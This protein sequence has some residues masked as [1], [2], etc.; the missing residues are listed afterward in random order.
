MRILRVAQ[1]V[2]PAVKGGGPYHVHAMSRDQATMGHDVTV[3]TI[4]TNPELPSIEERDGYTVIRYDPTCTVLGNDVSLDLAQYLADPP[5][6]DVIHAHSHLYFCSNLAAVRRKLTGDVPLVLTNHGLHSQNVS[7]N[8]FKMYLRTVG[9]WTFNQ[10]DLVFCYTSE[11]KERA[12]KLGITSE[13]EI[14]SNGIDPGR[15]TPSGSKHDAISESAFSVVSPIRLVP[16]KRPFD[17]V[18]AIERVSKQYPGVELYLCG[19]GPLREELESYIAKRNLTDVVHL[20]GMVPYDE[21][22]NV[23]RSADLVVLP[24]EA[25]GGSPRALLEGMATETPFISPNLPQIATQL[26]ELGGTTDVGDV[27]GLAAE[28]I[29]FIENNELRTSVGNRSRSL[30]M[31]EYNWEKTAKETTDATARLVERVG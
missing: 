8:L 3:L 19:D 17:V 27:E 9:L 31:E 5:D 12:E 21:M 23:Y 15:F 29:R 2:Y 26:K 1:K 7:K 16:G 13:I 30:V 6:F 4:R 18:A 25:E 28:I 24:S 14:V 10:A 20:L 22:P 11:G